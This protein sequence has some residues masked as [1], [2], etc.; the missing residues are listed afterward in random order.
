MSRKLL[1]IMLIVT[2]LVASLSSSLSA[3]TPKL[4]A[5]TSVNAIALSY[6]SIQI[7]WNKVSRASGYTLYYLASSG[8]KALKD[9]ALTSYVDNDSILEGTT[10]SYKVRA[11]TI[12]KGAKV[13]SGYSA[14]ASV[15]T[16][17]PGPDYLSIK[18]LSASSL[19]LEWLAVVGATSYTVY[20]STSE[21]GGFI[22]IGTTTKT[23]Y[24]D[25]AIIIGKTYFYKVNCSSIKNN[26]KIDSGFST[27]VI[28]ST[29]PAQPKNVIADDL[30][31]S[32]IKVI[33]QTVS[34]AT[35]YTVY[36][37]ETKT[38]TYQAINTTTSLYF[39][40]TALKA[41]TTY[42]YKVKAY[43]TYGNTK[44][45][46]LNSDTAIATTL[47]VGKKYLNVMFIGN[48]LTFSGTS[49]GYFN[50]LCKS[51]GMYVKVLEDLIGGSNLINHLDN[52]KKG[53][54]AEERQRADIVIM[55][56]F[57]GTPGGVFT[58]DA[59]NGIKKYF[60]KDAKFYFLPVD[61][62][63][64]T[65]ESFAASL[66]LKGVDNVVNFK[67][68][69]LSYY[70]YKNFDFEDFHVQGDFHP[71]D[72]YGYTCGS[73]IY[74]TLFNTDAMK[75]PDIGFNTALIPGET[76]AEKDKNMLLIKQAIN[77]SI[78]HK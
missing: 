4:T 56:E 21:N 17:T 78:K 54:Y 9:I 32:S 8:Y 12:V 34:G 39:V 35:G 46:G 19:K 37:S 24:T 40:N 68:S 62:H 74:C 18:C 65:T 23:T 33:W 45:Y 71:N 30:S 59:V 10:Y 15:T 43:N 69:Y 26:R 6:D 63:A 51:A 52:Y 1:C 47:A 60:R 42:Y 49:Q 75:L 14:V 50:K 57:G 2:L 66:E 67:T 77:S 41:N 72:L 7:S 3:A 53:M 11:Y 25:K 28:G 38:G 44:Q 31:S 55:Q 61:L 16:P 76:K 20:R 58:K 70:L 5:P 27:V 64:S 29:I 73:L 36:R 22:A 48:S 13:Y